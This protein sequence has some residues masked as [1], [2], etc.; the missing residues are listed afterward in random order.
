MKKVKNHREINQVK[1]FYQIQG[2]N[3]ALLFNILTWNN[4]FSLLLFGAD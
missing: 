3:S 2:T 1:K 4:F